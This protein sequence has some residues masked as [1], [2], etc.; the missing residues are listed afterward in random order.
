MLMKSSDTKFGKA[1]DNQETD[2]EI[3]TTTTSTSRPGVPAGIWATN[4]VYSSHG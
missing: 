1:N 3:L 2:W 4:Q